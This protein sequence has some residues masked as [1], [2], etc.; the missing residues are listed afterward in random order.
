M[1][2]LPAVMVSPETLEPEH[3]D[4][5]VASNTAAVAATVRHRVFFVAIGNSLDLGV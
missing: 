4:R 5:V 1:V 2:S 3:A